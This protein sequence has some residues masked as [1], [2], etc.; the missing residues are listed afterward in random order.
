MKVSFNRLTTVAYKALVRIK[1]QVNFA[2]FVG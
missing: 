2:V 1:F